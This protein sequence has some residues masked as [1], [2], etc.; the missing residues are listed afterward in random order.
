[1]SDPGAR[2]TG[3][4]IR[5]KTL[6]LFLAIGVV[7]PVIAGAFLLPQYGRVVRTSEARQQQIL[8]SRI[9][10][11]ISATTVAQRGA[12]A[13]FSAAVEQAA[14]LDGSEAAL[15][16]ALLRSA[17][18]STQFL[19]VVRL[20]IPL[21]KVDTIV[22]KEGVDED[23]VPPLSEVLRSQVNQDG[24][25]YELRQGG[26]AS[27][28]LP[29][30]GQGGAKGYVSATHHADQ[31][32]HELS[33]MAG[34]TGLAEASVVVTTV[35]GTVVA[36]YRPK[37]NAAL[38]TGADATALPAF[39]GV[40][41]G[42]PVDLTREF[43]EGDKPQIASLGRVDTLG[44]NVAIWRPTAL[45]LADYYR[46]RT[47]ALAVGALLVLLTAGLA[48]WASDAL[49]RPLLFVSSQ[50][51]KI[52]GRK[53]AELS[54]ALRRGDEVGT[55]SRSVAQMATDLQ[56]S[57]VEIQ[58]EVRRRSDLSRFLSKPLVDRILADKDAM[59][60]G[61]K[62]AEVTVVF[63]DMVAF[64]T[65]SESHP[66][67]HIV[68]LLNELFSVM[69]EVVFRHG[70]TV[71]KFIGDCLM[72]VWGAPVEHPDHA[73]RAVRAAR[74]MMRFLEAAADDW[75]EKYQ[76]EVRLAIGINS[77]RAIVGNVGSVKRMEY[78][79]VGDVVNVAARLETIAAPNQVLMS[80]ATQSR[81]GQ[82][83]STQLLGERALSGR[84]AKVGVHELDIM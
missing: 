43:E 36:A 38:P 46:V 64:T 10:E 49:T 76:V 1:M 24:F 2:R 50:A 29:V 59:A 17:L 45:A 34:E 63:A 23:S 16:P 81:L 21:A 32:R 39:D 20:T 11:R 74:D 12:L 14:G 8:L 65:A 15:A 79:V 57:E 6:A 35:E 9:R 80:D 7:I 55:L 82:E 77:G 73:P 22:S 3:L 48:L 70:G 40:V 66:P 62:H 18:A 5:Q 56:S 84:S 42:L 33:V 67:E 68:A 26:K 58:Q 61:G 37:G 13:M 28:A 25:G 52:G 19:D 60:L 51:A 69:T 83:F 78:T 75:Y 31:L 47:I 41:S 72:A 27:L 44:W 53:W 54:P 71:D 30:R 4:S